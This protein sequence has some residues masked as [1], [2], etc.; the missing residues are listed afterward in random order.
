MRA[1]FSKSFIL[2]ALPLLASFCRADDLT[3]RLSR[4][5]ASVPN[6]RFR[7]T[8]ELRTSAPAPEES[9]PPEKPEKAQAIVT[10]QDSSNPF[11]DRVFRFDELGAFG[12]VSANVEQNRERYQPLTDPRA[13]LVPGSD[14]VFKS[15]PVYNEGYNAEE[16]LY[17]Y[18]GKHLNPTARPLIE[19]GRELY[20]YG[21]LQSGIDLFGTKNLVFPQFF[22]FGDFRTAIAYNDN[23]AKQKGVFAAKLNL[24][25]DIRITATERIHAFFTPL[26]RDGQVSRFDFGGN[27]RD[28]KLILNPVPQALF[29]EGD[30]ARIAAGL[31]DTDNKYDIPFTF[32]L[33]PL[34]TQNGVWLQD[35]F[36]G[37]AFTIPA[38]NSP[39]LQISNMD[40]TFFAG[41][42]QVTTG[43]IPN[44]HSADVFGVAG[45]VE[46]R[47]GYLEFGYGYTLGR[48]D[49]DDLSYHNFS[50][51]FTRRYFDTISNSVRVVA[52]VGQDPEAGHRRTADGV[53]ILLEN[54]LITPK[55]LTLVPYLNLFSGFN[56]PQS[57]ARAGGAGGILVNTGLSFETDG[58]TGFPKLDD[59]GHDTYGGALGL[60]YLFA[61]DQQ[62]VVEVAGLNTFGD[63]KD[64]LAPGYQVAF[65]VRYQRPLNNAWI[66][67]ADLIAATR[68][69]EDDLFGV[70]L[71]LRRKF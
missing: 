23:G 34:I 49:F 6:E 60:E 3:P 55:P 29:F 63:E 13:R 35:A 67:R 52:N 25:V 40:L 54:S 36:N 61:F 41:F 22:V 66:L 14:R 65:G 45:F 37:F 50:V 70:R 27:D 19:L 16:Q 44:D 28:S 46:T 48:K 69:K 53:I 31:T 62:I 2:A 30:L 26:D 38:R 20:Q 71:E 47:Q 59:S 33:I 68:D 4:A 51:A 7:V 32:G 11:A 64:R 15:D 17:I 43:A 8:S 42:D 5:Q 39:S 9:A 18:G 10:W 21:P 24:D 12:L 1:V 57:I 58:I 56:K